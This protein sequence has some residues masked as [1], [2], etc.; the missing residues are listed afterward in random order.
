MPV[1][2]PVLIPLLVLLFS[3]RGSL[4][5]R[6]N[7]KHTKALGG[8]VGRQVEVIFD[9][10][11]TREDMLKINELRAQLAGLFGSEHVSELAD[12]DSLDS[13]LR[14]M[15]EKSNAREDVFHLL[16]RP[17]NTYFP[18]RKPLDFMWQA[19]REIVDAMKRANEKG[20]RNWNELLGAS[21]INVRVNKLYEPYDMA[22]VDRI[23]PPVRADSTRTDNG[24]ESDSELE[25]F[26]ESVQCFDEIY[27]R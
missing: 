15:F 19:E 24:E 10:T 11:F 12:A 16:F 2:I 6:S 27:E 7:H 4:E 14:S 21:E 18:R 25:E 3:P 26:T 8:L 9:G 22:E 23:L 13:Y 1:D 20:R 5:I 17:R